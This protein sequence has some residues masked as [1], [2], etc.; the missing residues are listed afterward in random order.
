MPSLRRSGRAVAVQ[1]LYQ[2]DAGHRF[3]EAE[4]AIELYLAHLAEDL[5]PEAER[6][7]K[8][9]C[10]GVVKHLEEIDEEIDRASSHWRTER[11]SRVDLSVLRLGVYELRFSGDHV[12]VA[13]V[14]DEAIEL[15]K[16][17]GSGESG[18]FINGVLSR[19]ARDAEAV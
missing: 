5:D 2:M 11:M 3:G 7:A 10:L 16:E 8:H 13:V 12:P 1:L 6:F 9:L 19:V 15:G 14:I 18:S 4:E 17:F